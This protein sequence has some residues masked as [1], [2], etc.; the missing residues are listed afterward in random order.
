MFTNSKL[1]QSL[2]VTPVFVFSI[3]VLAK[4]HNS[5]YDAINKL[6]VRKPDNTNLV[7]ACSFATKGVETTI[8]TLGLT[9]WNFLS[10][11]TT[12]NVETDNKQVTSRAERL[13][14]AAKQCGWLL[15]FTSETDK[16]VT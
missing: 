5:D 1:K 10:P 7:V 4:K 8:R 2:N 11:T 14:D 6:S 16:T 13:P 3:K 9:F 15:A 12:I